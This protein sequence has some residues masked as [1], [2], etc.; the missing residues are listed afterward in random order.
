MFTPVAAIEA[1]KNLLKGELTDHQVLKMAKAP[2]GDLAKDVQYI[3]DLTFITK[4]HSV[5][6]IGQINKDAGI[7]I[8]KFVNELNGQ[9]RAYICDDALKQILFHEYSRKLQHV[10]DNNKPSQALL[11]VA[12]ADAG[13]TVFRSFI[14]Y[15]CQAHIDGITMALAFSDLF[16]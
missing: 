5:D 15:G 6:E 4:E 9:L 3:I 10:F 1:I 2:D 16:R 8:D 11:K 13:E 7:K 14:Q 12:A